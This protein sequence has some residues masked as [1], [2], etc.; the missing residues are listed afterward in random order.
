MPR[1][2]MSVTQLTFLTGLN[3]IGSGIIMLPAKTAKIGMISLLA[4]GVTIA[5]VLALSHCFAKCGML[6]RHRGG[7]GGIA[8][9][10]FGRSGSFMTNYTYGLSLVIANVA[11]GITSVSYLTDF[12]G[13]ALSPWTS[14]LIT[15]ALLWLSTLANFGGP[16][17]TGRLSAAV[18]W[19]VLIPLLIFLAVGPF[20]FSAA[21]FAANWNPSGMPVA[22]AVHAALPMLL[23]SFLGL[24]SACANSESV[25]N[26]DKNVPKAVLLATV[27]VA[28]FFVATSVLVGG[29]V[30]NAELADSSAPFGIVFASL[31]GGTTA[32]VLTILMGLSCTGS[33]MAW[34]FTLSRVL[35]SS[36]DIGYFPRIFRKVTRKDVPIAGMVVIT[37]V[38]TVLVAISATP[39]LFGQFSVLVDL[40]VVTNII[41]YVSCIAPLY[42]LVR[43]DHAKLRQPRLIVFNTTVALLY[44]FY[45]LLT[46]DAFTMKLATL[47]VF[48]GWTI[49]AALVARN[50]VNAPPTAPTPPSP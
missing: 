27:G 28:F 47:A 37:L 22:D 43:L 49:Y 9:Y 11:I 16:K 17:V 4:W 30:P 3:M 13:F 32:K 48:S 31:F 15:V 44:V 21:L 26:P 39:S 41:P 34:Q 36:A 12:L 1:N 5:G 23:W 6:S 40:S 10:A 45:V 38:Q 14:G 2:K 24:E 7:L 35:K 25:D 50:N 46:M 20:H 33:M 42:L 19:G 29:M 18:F 8:E